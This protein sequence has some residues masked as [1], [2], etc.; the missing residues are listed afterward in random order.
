MGFAYSPDAKTVIRAGFGIFFD[1]NNL[2]FFFTTGNQKTLPGYFCNPP[3]ADP[4][5]AARIFSRRERFR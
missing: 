2:T 4:S 5:C 1:R 3:G